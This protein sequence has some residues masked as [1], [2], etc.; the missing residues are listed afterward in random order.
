MVKWLGKGHDLSARRVFL[1][2]SMHFLN[3]VEMKGSADFDPQNA[4]ALTRIAA[5]AARLTPLN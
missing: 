1:H 5:G 4:V 2:D 3:F